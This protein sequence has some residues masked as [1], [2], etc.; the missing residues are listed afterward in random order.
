MNTRHPKIRR[1]I[2][3][4]MD[5]VISS[6]I[7]ES[8]RLQVSAGRSGSRAA[9]TRRGSGTVSG[10]NAATLELNANA[11]AFRHRRFLL[12]HYHYQAEFLATY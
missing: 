8:Y 4:G 10:L 3:Q 6:V 9:T 5:T 2:E 1:Q 12:L 7:G 11:T